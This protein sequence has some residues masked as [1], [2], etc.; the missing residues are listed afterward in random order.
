MN[1]QHQ[2]REESRSD[3]HNS[4]KTYEKIKLILSLSETVLSIMLL[5]IFVIAGYSSQ[6]RDLVSAWV[7]NPWLRLLLYTG[8]LG[9]GFSVLG[10]PFS[11]ISAF[12]LEHHFGLSNQ[13]FRAWLWEKSKASAIGLIL[14]TPVLLIFYYFLLNF[15]GLWWLF[16]AIVL[17]IFSI[18]LGRVAPQ[19]I[20]PLFYKFEKIDDEDMISRMK[21]LARKGKF[22]L[23]GVYRFN[24]SKNTKKANAAFTGLGRS[25]RIILGDTLLDSFSIDEIETVFAHEVGHYVN[26]HLLTGVMVGTV[27]TFAG[28]YLAHI[29]YAWLVTEM[30]F[31]GPADLAGLPLISLILTGFALITGPLSNMLSRRHEFQAD[32]YALENSSAPASFISAMRKLSAM[33]LS[34]DQPHPLVEFL[35]HG[36]P[37]VS[38]R[39]AAA[40]R[41]LTVKAGNC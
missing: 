28:L 10:F 40:E 21:E 8:I 4:A 31:T 35:F 37:A 41:F 15:S 23:D 22:N 14:F 27:N 2:N 13:S 19:V 6:L 26:K 5:L 38:K 11:F 29:I 36:H 33:N 20:F 16:T 30:G 39:I 9:A 17:F 1:A 32:R 18:I 3:L 12:W 34:D 24:M 25:K 7:D